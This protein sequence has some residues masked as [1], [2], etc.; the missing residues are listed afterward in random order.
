[1]T[2]KAS[3]PKSVKYKKYLLLLFKLA[4]SAILFYVLISKVGGRT[5][6]SN[7]GRLDPLAFLGAVSLYLVSISIASLRWGLLIPKHIRWKDL[8]SMFMI[9]AFFNTYMPGI[10]G[11]DAVKAYYLSRELKAGRT[12]GAK[13]DGAAPHSAIGTAVAAV[14]MDRYIGLCA[15]LCLSMAVLPFGYEYLRG[16]SGKWPVVWFI[17]SLFAAYIAT[18][19]I[20]FKFRFSDRFKFLSTVSGYFRFYTSRKKALAKAFLYSIGVQMMGII[21]VYVL[22][23]GL[24]MDISFL[25]VL[26]FLPVIVVVTTVPVSI[27]G[28]GLREGAFV[29]LLGT[30]GVPAE[31]AMTLSL[32]WFLSF[33]AAG[34]LGLFYYL[35]FKGAFG[36]KIEE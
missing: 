3:G 12:G 20:I 35:R 27:S 10:I 33:V 32:A 29:F 17:P 22:S 23:R 16:A 21:A 31:M 1:M 5:I 14:F 4:I 34:L 6:I 36:G 19:I 15:M 24:S 13:R 7:M 26:V 30:I 8:F 11:G 28:I 25:S 18:G 2:A 9:G